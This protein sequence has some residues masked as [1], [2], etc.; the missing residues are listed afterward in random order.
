MGY[1]QIPDDLKAMVDQQVADGH[2]ASEADFIA[3]AVRLYLG[4]LEGDR[5]IAAMADRAD[6]DMAA[7]RYVTIVTPEDSEA[8]HQ[9]TIERLR[10]NLARTASRD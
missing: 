7:G 3:E 2:A 9:R 10:A 8:V 1:V 4:Y 5:L 6:A